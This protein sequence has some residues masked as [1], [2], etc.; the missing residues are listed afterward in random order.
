VGPR[1]LADAAVIGTIRTALKAA[2]G[3][4]FTYAPDQAR[5]RI[6]SPWGLL[7]GRAYYLVGPE[8]GMARP[9]LWRLDR[10]TGLRL[11]G[12]A[13]PPP[14]GWTIGDY[15]AQS[16]GVFQETPLPVVLLFSAQAAADA[17]RFLF[18]PGQ[19]MDRQDDGSL[20]VAF[21]AGGMRELATHLFGWGTEVQVLAPED[22]R[23]E[24]RDRLAAALAHHGGAGAVSQP[25]G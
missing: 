11:E 24:L 6:V 5:A 8:A 12:V 23:A 3:L 20:R 2:A 15:A 16:F 19:V 18:H 10:M 14:Q 1:P 13:T 7:Y 21:T 9:V 17:E 4:A 22:L 25:D